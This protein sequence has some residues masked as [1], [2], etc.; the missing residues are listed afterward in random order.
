MDKY[1][2][3]CHCGKVKFEVE[4]DLAS[5]FKCNCSFCVR[6]AAT[7]QKVPSDRFSLL[8]SEGEL[9]V[10][11]NR[12]FSKHYFCKTCG[13]NCF[14]RI[15]RNNESSV[16]VNIGCLQGVDSYSFNPMVFDGVN[17]L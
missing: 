10:Y 11:G 4:T 14:T 9:G 5:T 1:Q 3:N 8:S 16:A 15:K 13:S 17:K 2:G 7:M 12:D 6:R